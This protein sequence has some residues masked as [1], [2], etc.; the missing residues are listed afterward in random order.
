MDNKQVIKWAMQ[1]PWEQTGETEA[2]CRV[3]GKTYPAI[4]YDGELMALEAD[5]EQAAELE[6]LG[7]LPKEAKLYGASI[8][9][10]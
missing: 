4:W 1:H 3:T 5:A 6:A 9:D 10:V 8:A 7:V 2:R